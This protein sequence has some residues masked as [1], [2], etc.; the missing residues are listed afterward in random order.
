M[1]LHVE[2]LGRMEYRRAWAYQRD[3]VTRRAAGE[4]PDTLLL[5]EHDPVLTIGR[6]GDPAHVLA[7][8]T[9]LADRA[10]E[11]IRV[12]R[13]GEVTYHGPGQLV[14]YPIVRL[15][16]DG[17]L[18]RPFVRALEAAMADTAATY[19]ITAGRRDGYPGCWV[20]PDGPWPRKIGA[21]GLRLERGVTF[22]G[23]AFNVTTRLTDF[24][25]IDPCGLAGLDVTS[26]ARECGWQGAEAAPSTGSVRVAG[27]R[28]ATALGDRLAAAVSAAMG[29]DPG[30]AAAVE[31]GAQPARATV[32]GAA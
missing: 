30:A 23:I 16:D 24:S 9:Q 5:V 28:F 26:V 4:A 19:G 21:L 14:G 15:A 3:L 2:W 11:V 32:A 22:H 29:P 6:H 17:L 1:E 13:G 27:E 8:D 10:I 7:S 31:R 20:D 18:L 25:L 12:E